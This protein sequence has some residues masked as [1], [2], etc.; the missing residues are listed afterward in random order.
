MTETYLWGLSLE[1][2]IITFFII[3][4]SSTVHIKGTKIDNFFPKDFVNIEYE[5]IKSNSYNIA[6]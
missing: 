2:L 3:S 6:L 1:I 4:K 5:R